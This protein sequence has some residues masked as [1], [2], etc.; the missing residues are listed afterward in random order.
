MPVI[1]GAPQDLLSTPVPPAQGLTS[2]LVWAEESV[3]ATEAV[4][5]ST[6]QPDTL[7]GDGIIKLLPKKL[8][9]ARGFKAIERGWGE[10]ELHTYLLNG[11][12]NKSVA[13]HTSYITWKKKGEHS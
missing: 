5:D 7:G 9:G 13:K 10:Y 11:G 2:R 8:Q 1:D 12:A 3:T 6:A 4:S